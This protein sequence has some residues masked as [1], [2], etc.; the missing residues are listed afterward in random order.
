MQL[1]LYGTT[2]K[3]TLGT[4]L[5]EAI[6]KGFI[7][8]DKFSTIIFNNIESIFAQERIS[9]GDAHPKK[10]YATEGSARTMINLAMVFLQHCI[11]HQ[12]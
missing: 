7:P 10:E 2:G 12:K 11:Q 8:S 9:T 1:L 5:P 6:K 4:L 3:G